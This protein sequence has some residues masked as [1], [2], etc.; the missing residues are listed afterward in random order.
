LNKLLLLA[1]A[2]VM[3]LSFACDKKAAD[4]GGD[5][6]AA[7]A[8]AADE[9]AKSDEGKA[10]A[11]WKDEACKCADMACASAVGG[12]KRL[13]LET[14]FNP[15]KGPSMKAAGLIKEANTCLEKALKAPAAK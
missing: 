2:A 8:G 3:C 15:G 14:K 1:V 6:A 11:A 5:K 10:W 9:W 12:D 4:K 7:T 13:A